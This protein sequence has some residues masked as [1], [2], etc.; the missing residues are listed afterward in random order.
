ELRPVPFDDLPGIAFDDLSGFW[1]AF[2]SSC[3]HI[4]ADKEALRGA[5]PSLRGLRAAARRAVD[6]KPKSPHEVRAFLRR[7]FQPFLVRP[8]AGLNPHAHGFVTGYYEPETDGSEWRTDVFQEPLL[9]RPADLVNAT[10]LWQ[11]K[12][13]AAARR[14]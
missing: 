13:L 9:G 4:L 12:Q 14:G 8:R 10:L 6:V 11:G 2:E 3:A 1:I 5:S 7:F